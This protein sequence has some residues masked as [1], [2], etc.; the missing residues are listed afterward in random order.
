MNKRFK[1]Y[2]NRNSV[3]QYVIIES[4]TTNEIQN[5]IFHRCSPTFL[6]PWCLYRRN[7]H[8]Y[9]RKG[10]YLYLFPVF[11]WLSI[12]KKDTLRPYLYHN[13]ITI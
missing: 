11:L 13:F 12:V 9:Q 5:N 4:I 6:Q 10:L 2:R 8:V 3:T 1:L 7:K